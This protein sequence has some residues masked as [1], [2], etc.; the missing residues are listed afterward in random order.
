MLKKFHKL[1]SGLF[2]TGLLALF[3]VVAARGPLTFRSDGAADLY[4]TECA[5][6][7]GDKAELKFNR[8]LPEAELVGVILKGKEVDEPPDMPAFAEKGVTTEQSKAL[9]AYMK[10][11]KNAADKK[12]PSP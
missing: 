7:H 12:E 1:A 10:Q 8:N 9:V 2:G 4:K 6:C 3:T 5:S 11:L